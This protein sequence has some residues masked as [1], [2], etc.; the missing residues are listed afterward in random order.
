M[1]FIV[2]LPGVATADVRYVW[3]A[4]GSLGSVQTT[5]ITQVGTFPMFRINTDVPVGAE[6]LF[7]YDVNDESNFSLGRY[8][9]IAQP[10]VFADAFLQRDITGGSSVGRNVK[11]ALSFLRNKWTVIGSTLTVYDDDDTTVL[12]TA[13]ISSDPTAIPITGSNPT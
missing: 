10:D 1:I 3:L 5:G 2:S 13:D 8:Q 9:Q 4:S 11:Q 12:W 6:E 7:A